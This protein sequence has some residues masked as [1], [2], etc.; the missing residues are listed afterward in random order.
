[1]AR[2]SKTPLWKFELKT[3]EGERVAPK[4]AI[5]DGGLY[6]F[7]YTK[8]EAKVIR[9]SDGYAWQVPLWV[10]QAQVDA[11]VTQISSA[12]TGKDFLS[13]FTTK[14]GEPGM[15]AQI[16]LLGSMK[17]LTDR[18]TAIY[19]SPSNRFMWGTPTGF[20]VHYATDHRPNID[21]EVAGVAF[22]EL[23]NDGFI[24]YETHTDD[25]SMFWR[26]P[27]D[28]SG[29]PTELI[30]K[31]LTTDLRKIGFIPGPKGLFIVANHGLW[32]TDFATGESKERFADVEYSTL[33]PVMNQEPGVAAPAVVV[34]TKDE[35]L[36]LVPAKGKSAPLA[37]GKNRTWA[38][39]WNSGMF[40]YVTDAQDEA[41]KLHYQLH[42]V[43]NQGSDDTL[44]GPE[45]DEM[46]IHRSGAAV[47]RVL[48][49]QGQE[50]FS[51]T[52]NSSA[53]PKPSLEPADEDDEDDHTSE[54][55]SVVTPH[56]DEPATPGDA[57][58]LLSVT[59]RTTS[60]CSLSRSHSSSAAPGLV[61]LGL[62][63][64]GAARRSRRR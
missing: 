38:A 24:Y 48:L 50:L 32:E 19:A 51:V 9:L 64:V 8:S 57:P 44:I 59:K 16:S 21:F 1:M 56:E 45:S 41:G 10:G 42:A 2:G 52:V 63:A 7:A 22:A 12:S 29:E 54:G 30:P 58:R 15:L 17:V 23:A 47:S 55:S 60:G 28:G 40:L 34:T 11:P 6:V 37:H 61:L 39:G 31:E 27:A 25:T 26:R 46:V 33:Q 13:L 49:R 43:T 36:A 5:L 4:T 3:P 20:T 62:V 35:G 18:A 53:L 14:Q